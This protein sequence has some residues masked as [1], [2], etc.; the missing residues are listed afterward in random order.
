[1]KN[2]FVL[3]LLVCIAMATKAQVKLGQMAPEISLL[4]ADDHV[5][6]L[7]SLKGKVVLIDFWASWCGP[8][9]ASNPSVVNLYNKYQA[10]GFEIFGVSIDSKKSA[11][12]KAIAADKITYTQ[13]NDTN[14]WYAKVT[15]VYGVDAIPATFLLNKEGVIVAVNAEG[16][17]LENKIKEMLE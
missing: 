13:V 16:K 11:W 5:V 2:V 8:C 6:N 17:E 3:V 7:S 9:R 14:G 15:T 10:K 1:M 4:N 12:L